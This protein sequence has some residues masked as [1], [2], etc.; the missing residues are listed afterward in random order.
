VNKADIAERVGGQGARVDAVPV[1]AEV[2]EVVDAVAV[3]SATEVVA[4]VAVVDQGGIAGAQAPPVAPPPTPEEQILAAFAGWLERNEYQV[5][6]KWASAHTMTEVV[7]GKAAA[8]A[9]KA[10]ISGLIRMATPVRVPVKMSVQ[11]G[12][13]AQKI[14]AAMQPYSA[15]T[16]LAAVQFHALFATRKA[17][18]IIAVI[19]GDRRRPDEIVYQFKGLME[20]ATPVAR[21]GMRSYGQHH[22]MT[23]HPLIVYTNPEICSSHSQYILQQGWQ[24]WVWRK[25]YLQAAIV[26]MRAKRIEWAKY[27][28]R[29]WFKHKPPYS[30]EDLADVWRALE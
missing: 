24:Q 5:P 21:L 2:V 10:V 16:D 20:L 6:G 22:G 12:G 9:A 15:L 1:T 28:G 19:L 26:D 11:G 13:S 4:A 23:V 30:S 14:A 3:P 27:P 7:A 18:R 8:F 17:N 25:I 29:S